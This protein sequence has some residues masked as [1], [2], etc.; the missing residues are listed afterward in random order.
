MKMAGP[1]SDFEHPYVQETVAR[2]T[3]EETTVRGKLERLF[4]Y[5][6]DEVKFGFPKRWDVMKASQVIELGMGQCNNKSTLFLALCKA[7]EIPARVHYGLI[8]T[9][10][11]RGIFPGIA[12]AFMPR[13]GSHSWIEVEVE[14]RWRRV[15][16][17]ITDKELFQG[18]KQELLNKGWEI[19]YAV[20]LWEGRCSCEF[21]IDK[22]EFVQMGAVVGDHGIWDD[23]S[24]F[25]ATENYVRLNAFLM[26]TYELM[27][28]GLNK[29]I[30]KLRANR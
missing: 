4:Y 30:E 26:F 6:R 25:Y 3:R 1:L 14:R 20:A 13:Q 18:A 27:V 12:L 5:V 9:E 10:I 7:L 16:S 8:K 2:L 22:E 17:Y 11:M 15:D 24:E 28:G 29:K 19:G 21:N 23:A